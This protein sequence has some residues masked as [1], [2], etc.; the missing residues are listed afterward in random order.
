MRAREDHPVRCVHAA[1][2]ISGRY[3]L[4]LRP[5]TQNHKL[6]SSDVMLRVARLSGASGRMMH[7]SSS[8]GC[9]LHFRSNNVL[10]Q[11]AMSLVCEPS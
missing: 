11:L 9:I 2:E 4:I 10:E 7:V 3:T 1:H 5:S 8:R 6:S